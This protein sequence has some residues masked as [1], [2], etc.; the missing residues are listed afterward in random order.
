[1]AST[2]PDEL[3]ER[4]KK[5]GLPVENGS[6]FFIYGSNFANAGKFFRFGTN[7]TDPD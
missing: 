4:A 3:V 7:P 5:Y 1:M 2:I 6:K